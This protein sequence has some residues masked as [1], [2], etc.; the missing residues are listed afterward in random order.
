M[1]KSQTVST[2]RVIAFLVVVL[3]VIIGAKIWTGKYGRDIDTGL[4]TPSTA[5]TPSTPFLASTM[6][7]DWL[8]YE[9]AMKDIQTLTPNQTIAP[10]IV[11]DPS[12]SDVVYFATNAWSDAASKETLSIYK[13]TESTYSFERIWRNSYA[14]G[15]VTWI[16]SESAV[17][18]WSLAGYDN[19]KL[20]VLMTD[21]D[22]SPGP[23]AQL[24]LVG[25]ANDGVGAGL[26]ALDLAR[27]SSGLVPYTPPDAL[28]LEATAAEESCQDAME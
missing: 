21:A 8:R 5:L 4:P 23:C 17:P 1:A 6:P 25:L 18:V 24:L 16:P 19:G 14:P 2:P 13:Y 26:F 11:D 22:N 7:E 9:N 28:I 12:D 3:I 20:I 15:D 27:P 10:L